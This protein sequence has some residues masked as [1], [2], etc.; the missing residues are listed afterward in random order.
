MRGINASRIIR[1]ERALDERSACP[2]RYHEGGPGGTG[3]VME[4]SDW[5]PCQRCQARAE[6]DPGFYFLIDDGRI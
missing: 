3:M 4:N 1:I 2:C 6:R 5:T